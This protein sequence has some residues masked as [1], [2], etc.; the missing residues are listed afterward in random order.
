MKA[1][2]TKHLGPT[3]CRGARIKASDED[4]NSVTIP[5]PYEIGNIEDKHRKAA[6]ALCTKMQ[7][8]GPLAAGSLKNGYVFVFAH[9][10]DRRP[11]S[12]KS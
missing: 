2:Q 6:A 3:N 8:S 4:G 10:A 5:Y 9:V 1:I 11:T 7:W 12:T